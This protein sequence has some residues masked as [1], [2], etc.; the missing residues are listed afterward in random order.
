MRT[1]PTILLAACSLTTQAED[2]RW[3]FASADGPPYVQ[4]QEQQLRGGVIFQLGQLASRKLGYGAEFVE[5]PNKRID[6]FMQ[7][8]RIHVI[9][10][11]NP[12][13]MDRPERYHWSEPLY[14]EEDVLL[15]HSQQ[16]PISNLQQLYGK[17]VGTQLGYVYNAALMDA[18]AKRQIIRQ[19][20]RD[21]SAGLHL[22]SKQ[23]LG[24]IIDMRRTLRLAL[25]KHPGAPLQL[26][27]WVIERYNMHCTYGPR[28]PVSAGQLDKVLLE[29]RDQGTIE[30][31]LNSS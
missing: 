16:A 30:Q 14:S 31:L 2:L 4:V 3:G 18:F 11:S 26:N 13:W 15:V 12:Q 28:L 10:N 24:A 27:P 25:S 6:E 20:V 5:T 8:G 23:R 7:R 17:T 22:L 21:P 19:D 1:L 9:C 29:L